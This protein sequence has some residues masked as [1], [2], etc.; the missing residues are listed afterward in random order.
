MDR[1][2]TRLGVTVALLIAGACFS[3]N[4]APTSEEVAQ[5]RGECKVHRDRV[6]QRDGFVRDA[7]KTEMGV[8]CGRANALMDE[9]GGTPPPPS[10]PAPAAAPATETTSAPE[11]SSTP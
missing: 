9:F 5:A 10:E 2:L 8:A 11:A 7:E 1:T 6:K 4:A 3:V